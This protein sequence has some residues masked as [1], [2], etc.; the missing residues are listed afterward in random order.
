MPCRYSLT[1]DPRSPRTISSSGALA[2][3]SE[4]APT[5]KKKWL[6]NVQVPR[7]WIPRVISFLLLTIAA[8]PACHEVETPVPHEP[9]AT[10]LNSSSLDSL[11][12]L[13]HHQL[14]KRFATL[15][16]RFE[17]TTGTPDERSAR[18]ER[19]VSLY[20]QRSTFRKREYPYNI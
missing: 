4:A 7:H 15:L 1:I 17:K 16:A 13:T 8:S 12:G 18:R 5:D 19:L 9:K 2:T 20:I 3:I 10:P 6:G 11:A 14:S